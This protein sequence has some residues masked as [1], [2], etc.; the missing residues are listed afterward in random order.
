MDDD[1]TWLLSHQHLTED[2]VLRSTVDT[3]TWPTASNPESVFR[4][5]IPYAYVR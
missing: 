3:V 2:W 5:L 1:E 4:S